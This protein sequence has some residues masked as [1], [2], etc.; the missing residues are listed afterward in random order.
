MIRMIYQH[1]SRAVNIE[2]SRRCSTPTSHSLKPSLQSFD[3]QDPSQEVAGVVRGLVQ[4]RSATLQRDCIEKYFAPDASFD[5]PMCSVSSS[6]NVSENDYLPE[7]AS[8][9]TS[10]SLHLSV[11]CSQG[12][13][14]YC[15][16]TNGLGACL[17][18]RSK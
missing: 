16:S 3:M 7:G 2:E 13:L 9:F 12:I 17:I 11:Y 5:H 14:A 15:P 6:S 1:S 8:S 4:A 18:L 10:Y